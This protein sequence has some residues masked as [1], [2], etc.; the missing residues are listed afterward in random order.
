MG[1]C[2]AWWLCLRLDAVGDSCPHETHLFPYWGLNLLLSFLGPKRAS[3]PPS[4]GEPRE[5]SS[6]ESRKSLEPQKE[7]GQRPH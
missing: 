6:H 4:R 2:E 7:Q 1:P 3:P 5:A